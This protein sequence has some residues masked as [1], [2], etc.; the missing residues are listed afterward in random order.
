MNELLL[1]SGYFGFVITL[2]AYLLGLQVKRKTKLAI[3]NPLL[4]AVT[5]IIL[6]LVVFRI[7]YE[8]YQKGS[9]YVSY[10]LT[11][12]TVCLA[13]PLYRQLRLLKDHLAAVAGGIASG[14]LTSILSIYAMSRLF[15]LSH[16]YYV[17][18]LPKSI[19]TAIGMG[20]SQE[21]GGIV[22]LTVV[23]IILTGILGNVIGEA[24]FRLFSISDP[25]A[26]GLALG[27]SAHAIGTAKA[28]ELGEIE[29]AMSS[30]AIAVAGLLTVAAVP[31]VSGWI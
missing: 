24:V 19:T 11:P 12:A 17:T 31:L 28:L 23:S 30:L 4:V 14:V 15:G 22:V 27:T 20:V 29:G 10:L 16:E 13:I 18:L 7:D 5:L 26:K 2:G 6:F 3:M 9:Q 21:A 8:V 1:N 25:I